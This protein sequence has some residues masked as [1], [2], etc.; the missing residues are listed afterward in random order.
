MFHPKVRDVTRLAYW[1]DL[2]FHEASRRLEAVAVVDMGRRE[3]RSNNA[4]AQ[5]LRRRMFAEV[6]AGFSMGES[7]TLSDELWLRLWW[8]VPRILQEEDW[9][10]TC[11]CDWCIRGI[12]VQRE[13]RGWITLQQPEN[14]DWKFLSFRSCRA[15]YL[16]AV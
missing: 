8:T 15:P 3:Y 9:G 6:G 2:I 16:Q 12:I 14:K 10:G 13:S 4:G 1:T 5:S 7:L 11:A